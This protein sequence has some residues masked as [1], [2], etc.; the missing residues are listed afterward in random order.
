MPVSAPDHSSPTTHAYREDIFPNPW[1]IALN[2][3]ANVFRIHGLK[4][5]C[6]LTLGKN[7]S[8]V[9]IQRET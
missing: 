3:C 7:H 4:K 8:L 9:E 2:I 1:I 5:Q 6:F